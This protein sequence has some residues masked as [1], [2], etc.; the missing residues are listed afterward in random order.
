MCSKTDVWL[1]QEGAIRAEWGVSDNNRRAKFYEL[2]RAGR[3]QL[4]REARNLGQTAVIVARFAACTL[5]LVLTAGC[6]RHSPTP[7]G[8]VF[9]SFDRV[10]LFGGKG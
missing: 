2:M 1:E 5:A 7:A 10:L 8:E 4:E 3:K 9:R 6:R